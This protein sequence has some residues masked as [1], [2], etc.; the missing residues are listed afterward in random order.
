[1]APATPTDIPVICAVPSDASV[2][3]GTASS[4]LVEVVEVG[5]ADEEVGVTPE[6]LGGAVTKVVGD[7]KV[8]ASDKE[9]VVPVDGFVVTTTTPVPV[10]GSASVMERLEWTFGSAPGWPEHMLYASLT[11][12]A[13]VLSAQPDTIRTSDAG[14]CPLTAGFVSMANPKLVES[15][16]ALESTLS[17]SEAAGRLVGAEA[18]EGWRSTAIIGEK[19]AFHE[20]LEA[21]LGTFWNEAADLAPEIQ[22]VC[23]GDR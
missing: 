9:L 1:M 23:A 16:D 3:P 11:T 2:L 4:S 14:Q 13:A 15:N 19:V 21:A 6:V 17:N 20:G 8:R 7:D 22:A 10:G 18:L 5:I 12:D